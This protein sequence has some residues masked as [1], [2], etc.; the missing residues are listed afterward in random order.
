MNMVRSLLQQSTSAKGTRRNH[1]YSRELRIVYYLI[2]INMHK[3][4]YVTM[5]RALSKTA[6]LHSR[7]RLAKMILQIQIAHETRLQRRQFAERSVYVYLPLN[8]S[9]SG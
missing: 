3:E 4:L 6:L 8:S 7:L 5:G 9:S 2:D 1:T